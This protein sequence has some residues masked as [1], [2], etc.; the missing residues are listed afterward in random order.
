MCVAS[1][2]PEQ[3]LM[4]KHLLR[5]GITQEWPISLSLFKTIL[6]LS[7]SANRESHMNQKEVKLSLF[8]DYISFFS[9]T[10]KNL[11]KLLRE[12]S[13]VAGYK[14]NMQNSAGFIYKNNWLEVKDPFYNCNKNNKST[15]ASL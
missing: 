10:E 15:Q 9:K 1:P 8:T 7:S 3:Y 5:S 14:I 13:K 2:K 6:K 11:A 12:F 4:R